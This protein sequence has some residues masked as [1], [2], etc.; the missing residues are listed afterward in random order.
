MSTADMGSTECIQPHRDALP[1]SSK[2]HLR[3]A[4]LSDIHG[5]TWALEAVIRDVES[6]HPHRF[7]ILGD[8]LADGPD[9]VGTLSLLRTL[10][11]AKHPSGNAVFVQGNTDRYLADLSQVMPPRSAMPDLVATWQWAVDRLGE[12]GRDFL[13]G[14]PTDTI[15]ETPTGRVLATHGVP[16]NDE[17]FIDPTRIDTF[18]D[19]DWHG[20]RLLLVGHTH[21]PFTLETRAADSRMGVGT[22]VNPGSVGL[23]APTGWRASYAILDLYSDGQ[24]AVQHVQVTWDIR[25]YVAAFE[26]RSPLNGGGIP[27]NRKAEPMLKELRHRL[28]S[29]HSGGQTS[30]APISSKVE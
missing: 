25:A 4:V 30:G 23:A 26:D 18:T 13:A 1:S 17:G 6:H 2:E 14:L 21:R 7:V 27:L 28:S 9:P 10:P 15:I 20:A 19:L 16:G 22:I 24:I 5:N 3:L 12:E 11:T 8:L 29:A